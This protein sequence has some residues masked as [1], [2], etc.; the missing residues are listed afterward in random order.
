MQ[1]HEQEQIAERSDPDGKSTALLCE[2]GCEL[3]VLVPPVSS[4]DPSELDQ[5]EKVLACLVHVHAFWFQQC[6]TCVLAI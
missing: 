6:T 3:A 1:E 2:P 5:E 4:A